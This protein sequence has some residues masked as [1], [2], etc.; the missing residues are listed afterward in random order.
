MIWSDRAAGTRM[1][2]WSS[3]ISWFVLGSVFGALII[4]PVCFLCSISSF[5]FSP[6]SL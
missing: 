4:E 3:R 2:H 5:M 6:F 1:L